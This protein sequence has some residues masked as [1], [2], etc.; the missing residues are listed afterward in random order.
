MQYYNSIKK[1]ITAT[2]KQT[3]VTYQLSADTEVLEIGFDMFSLFQSHLEQYLQ[4]HK[5]SFL[6]QMS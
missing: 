6:V 5:F 2:D 4:S 3:K 1:N